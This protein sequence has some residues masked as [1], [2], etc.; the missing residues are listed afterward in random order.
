MHVQGVYKVAGSVIVI[1]VV[2]IVRVTSLYCV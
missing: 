2:H 1:V